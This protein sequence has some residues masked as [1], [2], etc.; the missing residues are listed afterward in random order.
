[1]RVCIHR[2]FMLKTLRR[3]DKFHYDV[4]ISFLLY[5]FILVLP[6]IE[7]IWFNNFR[8]SLSEHHLAVAR[9]PLAT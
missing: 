1:M 2:K 4:N 7:N 9:W 3:I 6:Y 8:I 5:K